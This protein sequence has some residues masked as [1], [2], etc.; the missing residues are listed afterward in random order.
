M[1]TYSDINN[2]SGV[3]RYEIGQDCIIVEFE[4]GK[5]RFYKYTHAS[6]GASNVEQMKLLARVG[7][8]LNEF[9]KD[10]KIGYASK[11]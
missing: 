6:A 2:D 5:E 4:S 7:D 1:E 11:W 10:N 3:L 8:G 9:V